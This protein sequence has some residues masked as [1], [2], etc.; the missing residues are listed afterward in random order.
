MI[1]QYI[2]IY[3]NKRRPKSKEHETKGDMNKYTHKKKS[4]KDTTHSRNY[5]KFELRREGAIMNANVQK[6]V[7]LTQ[8][9]NEMSYITWILGKL[10]YE[11]QFTGHI[12]VDK[13]LIQ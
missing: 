12:Q 5:L 2:S 10:G 8:N 13:K 4:N 7:E 9:S 6:L 11:N 1:F 3:G